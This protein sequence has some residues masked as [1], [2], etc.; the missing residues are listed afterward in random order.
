VQTSLEGRRILITGGAVRVGRAI[1][2]HV[3]R[4][5][6]HVAI[7]YRSSE[8]EAK[9]LLAEVRALGQPGILIQ[10]DLRSP[11]GPGWTVDTAAT[12]LGGLDVLIN[13]ASVFRRTP[14]DKLTDADWSLHLDVNLTA[15][16]RC[17]MAA[18]PHME[19]QGGGK[20]VNIVDLSAF[21]PWPG[22]IAHSVSKAGLLSLTRGLARALAHRNI[23]VNAVAPG[24]VLWPDDMS[25]EE[26]GRERSRIPSATPGRPEDVAHAVAYLLTASGF[27][28]GDCL[29]VDGARSLV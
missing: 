19:A 15:P 2:L 26:I 20:I 4:L 12:A 13:N 7:H 16:F 23:Q 6:A 17:A 9:S 11:D 3:A 14:V 25:V 22:F 24:A 27:V 18:L 10:A 21:R 1:A 29:T 28:T 5:G 8:A